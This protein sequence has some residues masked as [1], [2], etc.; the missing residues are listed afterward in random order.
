[1]RK[2]DNFN[3]GSAARK[4]AKVYLEVDFGTSFSILNNLTREYFA[5]H[6]ELVENPNLANFQ[7]VVGDSAV[8]QYKDIGDLIWARHYDK[9]GTKLGEGYNGFIET[10]VFHNSIS[11]LDQARILVYGFNIQGTVAAVKRL[12]N[13]QTLYLDMNSYLDAGADVKSL[14]SDILDNDDKLGLQVM[15]LLSQERLGSHLQA[16]DEVL[17]RAVQDVYYDNNV[18]VA[19][20]PVKTLSSTSYGEET[21]LRTKNLNIDYST[22]YKDVFSLYDTPVVM[23]GGIYS[24]LDVFADFGGELVEDGHDVW[25][26]EITGGPDEEDN[27][28]YTY[29]DLEDYYVPAL[30]AGVQHYSGSD[31]VNYVGHSNGCR[32][33]LTSL[34]K[35]YSGEDDIG[36]AFN[37]STGT[38]DSIDLKANPVDKFFGIACPTT[39][40]GD[41]AGSYTVNYIDDETG[42]KMGDLAIEELENE[43]LINIYQRDYVSKVGFGG[44]RKNKIS[45][46]LQEFYNDLYTDQSS[47][48]SGNQNAASQ[49]IFFAGTDELYFPIPRYNPPNNNDDDG[50]VPVSD[51]ELL[52]NNLENS[53]LIIV[54]KNHMTITDDLIVKGKIIGVLRDD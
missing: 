32:S 3:C 21:Q 45:L 36:Y 50:V 2:T 20:L 8:A 11:N 18:E 6:F 47:S 46:K 51:L 26:I 16:N 22:K 15:D 40:N 1:M 23:A 7:V 35:H 5:S 17:R 49:Y 19:I 28:P 43:G 38:W 24:N 41:T 9:F 31:T 33:A 27:T 54:D 44:S 14:H 52:S 29:E 39:L 34:S 4:K 13:A 30:L 10:D 48:F 12:I 25:L 42:K 37:Y 53:E